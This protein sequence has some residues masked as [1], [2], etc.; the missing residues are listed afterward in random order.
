MVS[1][2]FLIIFL[3]GLGFLGWQ[4]ARFVFKINRIELLLPLSLAIG[5][6]VYTFFLNIFSHLIPIGLNFYI[7]FILLVLAALGLFF[8]GKQRP[9]LRCELSKK[10]GLIVFSAVFIIMVLSGL[11]ASR[12]V[13]SDNLAYSHLP[14]AASIAGGNFPVKNLNLPEYDIAVHYGPNLFYAAILKIT[15]F[16]IISAFNFSV[17]LFSGIIFLLIFNIAKLF[18]KNNLGSF[19][20][21]LVGM[22]G[23]GFRFIYGFDGLITL[24][25]KFILYYNIEHP[26]KFFGY[27]WSA[28]PL[29]GPLVKNIFYNWGVLGWVLALAV[30]YLYLRIIR[31]KKWS[32]YYDFLIIILLAVLALNFEMAFLALCFGILVI[33]FIFYF[34]DK[35]K[36]D[37]KLLLKHSLLILT[38]AAILVLFQGGTITAI[39]KNIIQHKTSY[40]VGLSFSIFKNPLAFDPG[41]GTVFPFYSP[42]F[43]LNFGL[44][45]FLIIPAII[46]VIKKYFKKSIFLIS[47]S[48]ISFLMPLFI[49]FNNWLWQGTMDRFFRFSSVI[50]AILVGLFLVTILLQLKN[51]SFFKKVIYICLIIIC[52]EGILFLTT[53]PLYKRDAYRLDN[54]RFFTEL[55]PLTKVESA[56]Y[57]WVKDNSCIKDYFLVFTDRND[58][59]NQISIFQN[60]RFVIFAQRLAPV[61]TYSNNYVSPFLPSDDYYTPIYKRLISDCSKDDM[62]TLNY[63]YLFVDNNW[64]ERFEE[65]CLKN[66]DLELK[67]KA[68]EGKRFI[69]IY[70]IISSRP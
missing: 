51:R 36:E 53:R 66:N 6:G 28:S 14:A 67:F 56:A 68:E 54:N 52:L 46:F 34:K 23:G 13:G 44:V 65:K 7:I 62:E 70:K 45:Y 2:F 40:G 47:I 1:I 26:F 55:R 11:I 10:E 4:I 16:S 38:I 50:W 8:L 41:N 31:N 37:F 61:Y 22:F 30:I 21:A 35:N 25:K 9:G 42:T 27:I 24:F 43:I 59:D 33:P 15:G 19:L 32:F 57:D 69:R 64:P 5:Y 12:Q 48:C 49:S 18:I 29:T 17:F 60:F 58:I 3:S 20:V 39:L 63:K